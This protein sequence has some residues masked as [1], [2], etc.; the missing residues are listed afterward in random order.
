[1]GSND[2]TLLADV[3]GGINAFWLK[4][5]VRR[6]T[7]RCQLGEFDVAKDDYKK[8]WDLNKA[9]VDLRDDYEKMAKLAEVS[10]MKKQADKTFAEG[11]VDQAIKLYTAAIKADSRFV[12]AVSNRAGALL[13]KGRYEECIEDCDAAL[14][15]LANLGS[16]SGPVP[17]PGSDKRRDWVIATVC[18][19]GK[20]RGETGQYEE[21]AKD[22]EM[23]LKLV[24][25]GRTKVRDSLL[26]DIEKLQQ[27]AK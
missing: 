13:A 25:E 15:M 17:P 21:A 19:R 1:M 7:A 16:T 8:A 20:A 12:S 5:F 6:G 2:Q 14:D 27:L 4:L 11:E 18:R 23:A 24:P 26:C 10:G 22:L 9:S 3:P